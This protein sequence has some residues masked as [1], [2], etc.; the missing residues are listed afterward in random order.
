MALFFIEIPEQVEDVT[1]F[2]TFLE[3]AN[4]M[5]GQLGVGLGPGRSG[6]G[7]LSGFVL[8]A[9]QNRNNADRQG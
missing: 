8:G 3:Q 5:V 9:R 4:V 7:F 1:V 2:G 6:D